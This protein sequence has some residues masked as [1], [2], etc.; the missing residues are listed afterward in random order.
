MNPNKIVVNQRARVA[1]VSFPVH[2]WPR[3]AA[4]Q[5]PHFAPSIFVASLADQGLAGLA[6]TF[7]HQCVQD[8]TKGLLL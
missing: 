8:F 2:W 3:I 4:I 1:R 7:F 5:T 6:S